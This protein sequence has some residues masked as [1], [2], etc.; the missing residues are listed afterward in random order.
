MLATLFSTITSVIRYLSPR[1]FIRTGLGV[2]IG[3]K[4]WQKRCEY[5]EFSTIS[6]KNYTSHYS[7]TIEKVKLQLRKKLSIPRWNRVER[8]CKGKCVT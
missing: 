3:K 6:E 8:S 5:H 4:A 7:I 2:L 1:L